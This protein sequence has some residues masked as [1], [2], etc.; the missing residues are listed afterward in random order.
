M[1]DSFKSSVNGVSLHFSNDY[2]NSSSP[3]FGGPHTDADKLEKYFKKCNFIAF[4][5]R[6][7]TKQ[8]FIAQLKVLA[9][10][11]YPEGCNRLVVT[12]S[13]HGNDGTLQLHDGESI[14]VDD[15]ISKFKPT[16]TANPTLGRMV[17]M[18]FFDA[19]RG[20]GE[21]SGYATRST[22]NAQAPE[23]NSCIHIC[24]ANM[25]VAYSCMRYHCAFE[26]KKGGGIWT[27][28]LLKELENPE[29][30]ILGVLTNVNAKMQRYQKTHKWIQTADVQCTLAEK[31]YFLKEAGINYQGMI[32]ACE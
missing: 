7:L 10:F 16:D 26:D 24:D 9:E 27:N 18:F 23:N 15:V 29:E 2:G 19:C 31:I 8:Q 14:S 21:G 20:N 5:Q 32:D 25:L 28:C 4:K 12:F 13:G 17:R 11:H 30:D 6:N 1:M 3:L 22:T